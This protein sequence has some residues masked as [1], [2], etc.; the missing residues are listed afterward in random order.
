MDLGAPSP[1]TMLWGTAVLNAMFSV[2]VH[3]IVFGVGAP[4]SK[5]KT[6]I[7]HSHYRREVKFPGGLIDEDMV[8]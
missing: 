5:T 2:R 3:N 7:R 4:K 8:R 1:N 6:K